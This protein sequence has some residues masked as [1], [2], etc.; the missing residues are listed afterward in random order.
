MNR[1]KAVKD[2]QNNLTITPRLVSR[3]SAPMSFDT[4]TE[5]YEATLLD[6]SKGFAS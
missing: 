1:D 6:V 4:P 3:D 2:V 5:S